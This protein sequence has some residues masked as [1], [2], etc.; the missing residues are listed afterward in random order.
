MRVGDESLFWL[1]IFY[2]HINAHSI[3]DILRLLLV[4]ASSLFSLK[5]SFLSFLFVWQPLMS[6]LAEICLHKY[7]SCPLLNL[8]SPMNP[9]VFNPAT[10]KLFEYPSN[11]KPTCTSKKPAEQRRNELLAAVG[12]HLLSTCE[13]HTRDLMCSPP[14]SHILI[15]TFFNTNVPGDKKPLAEAIAKC[16]AA[17]DPSDDS[18][19]GKAGLDDQPDEEDVGPAAHVLGHK[20]MQKLLTRENETVK[21]GEHILWEAFFNELH[22]FEKVEQRLT[23]WAKHNRMA[24]VLVALVNACPE[25]RKSDVK[26]FFAPVVKAIRASKATTAC[27]GTTKLLEV[28]EALK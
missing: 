24:F 4:V 5:S 28:L 6:E 18:R 14:G 15:E 11:G 21:E 1:V 27:A 20:V 12:P 22:N 17:T 25:A 3:P 13:A 8:L 9:Q 2:S 19:H 16:V 10:Q 26:A 23:A 7:A